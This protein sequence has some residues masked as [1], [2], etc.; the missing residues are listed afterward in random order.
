MEYKMRVA[1]YITKLDEYNG[2]LFLYKFLIPKVKSAIKADVKI[3][4]NFD[5]TKGDL[6]SFIRTSI[7]EMYR[8]Y[9]STD[10]LDTL[11][12]EGK[13]MDFR[14]IIHK[15]IEE[16]FNNDKYLDGFFLD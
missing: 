14:H 9:D 2:S 12:F 10:I 5:G 11:K 4:L 15:Y 13:E 3:K 16:E 6:R 7:G 1:E 8:Y